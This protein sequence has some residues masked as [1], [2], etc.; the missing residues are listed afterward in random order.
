MNRNSDG[1]IELRVKSN[2]AGDQR[3]IERIA[4]A[5]VLQ[6]RKYRKARTVSLGLAANQAAV[7]AAALARSYLAKR[8]P[9][10]MEVSFEDREVEMGVVKTALLLDYVP[11]DQAD[12]VAVKPVEIQVSEVLISPSRLAEAVFTASRNNPDCDS[13]QLTTSTMAELDIALKA[14]IQLRG[15]M[16]TYG[17]ELRF[18]PT[19]GLWRAEVDKIWLN[20][21]LM[22]PT[23]R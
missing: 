23:A 2:A 17:L 16:P 1:P 9:C 7:C 13:V 12:A 19:V 11:C 20:V 6:F 3:R 8:T 10:L 18:Y 5:V 14:M 22:R 4:G 15:E 21:R